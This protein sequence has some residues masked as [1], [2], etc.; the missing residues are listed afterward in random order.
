MS[1][2]AAQRIEELRAQI[3]YHNRRYH[4]LDEPE[5][6]DADYDA[7]VR[8]LRSLEDEH[9]ELVTPDSPTQTVGGAPSVLFAPVRHAVPMMSLDNAM[10][11]PELTAWAQRIARIDPDA[12]H[13]DFVCELKIDG[14]AMSLTYEDG[15]F[16]RAATRGDGVTGEDVTANVATI[17]AVPHELQ[18]PKKNGA[19][20]QLFEARGEV[21][22]PVPA[23]DELNRRQIEAGQKTFAN[24]RNSAAG[25]LRQKD[26]K[27]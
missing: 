26:P 19:V 13:A 4:E 20:P 14:L 1:G 10:D 11:L 18:W 16:V 15:R 12:L 27:I 6:S 22:M 8:E 21:Y 17:A 23:F 24:P 5:I 9:P 25:S 2:D 7:L 3:A